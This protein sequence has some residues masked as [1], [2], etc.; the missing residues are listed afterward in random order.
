MKMNQIYKTMKNQ[1]RDK[2]M[3]QTVMKIKKMINNPKIM[4]I[5]MKKRLILLYKREAY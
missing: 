2:D 1:K 3:I 4:K 5:R